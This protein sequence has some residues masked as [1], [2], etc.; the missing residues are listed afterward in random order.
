MYRYV[1][2]CICRS[3]SVVP[4]LKR[5]TKTIITEFLG[6]RQSRKFEIPAPP[7]H[8]QE[9]DTKLSKTT[10]LCGKLALGR[11][12]CVLFLCPRLDK[13]SNR[14]EK[15]VSMLSSNKIVNAYM[16]ISS[17]FKQCSEGRFSVYV[18]EYLITTFLVCSNGP[19]TGAL[20]VEK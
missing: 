16:K 11:V 17:T 19:S 12:H 3:S 15:M 10:M 2:I 9:R 8:R 14:R 7:R 5:A 1:Y 4:C 20:D 6:P 18:S 13:L